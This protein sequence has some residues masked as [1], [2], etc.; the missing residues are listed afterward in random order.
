[1]L[2]LDQSIALNNAPF[3]PAVGSEHGL[4]QKCDGSTNRLERQRGRFRGDGTSYYPFS[5]SSVFAIV[6]I[7][8]ANLLKGVHSDKEGIS[9]D[10]GKGGSFVWR[11][12]RPGWS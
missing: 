8:V 2:L 5:A 1:M 10:I 12:H 4:G 6:I 7:A 9:V 11:I 3:V